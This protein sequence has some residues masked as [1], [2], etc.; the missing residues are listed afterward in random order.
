MLEISS[1]LQLKQY[2]VS[3]SEGFH[4]ITH[5]TLALLL[6]SDVYSSYAIKRA[7]LDV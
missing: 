5:Y 1:I 4:S 7:F 2:V 3:L 6:V